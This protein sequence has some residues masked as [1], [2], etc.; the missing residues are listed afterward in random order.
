MLQ[1]E[2]QIRR[3]GGMGVVALPAIEFLARKIQVLALEILVF[4]VVTIKADRRHRL[5]QEVPVHRF[6]GLMTEQTVS[7][8][9]GIV[10][11]STR[12][13]RLKIRMAGEADAIGAIG[14]QS[15]DSRVMRQVAGP[16]F[17]FRHRPVGIGA[18]S[19]SIVAAFAKPWHG[20]S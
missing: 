14:Q 7:F 20:F 10:G 18:P 1:I 15:L 16:A 9:R 5:N 8:G 2:N 6:M 13:S 4:A 19:D 3:L 17:P 11:L 12:H